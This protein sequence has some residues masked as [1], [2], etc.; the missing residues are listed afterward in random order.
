MGTYERI[1]ELRKQYGIS[2]GKLEKELKI[3]NGSV[4][5]WRDHNPKAET[6]KKVADFFDVPVTYLLT[7]ETT[8]SKLTKEE[9]KLLEGFRRLNDRGRE[10]ILESIADYLELPKYTHKKAV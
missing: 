2:Q 6:L 4:N 1:E 5:K 10:K 7:G 8:D 9:S 3:A